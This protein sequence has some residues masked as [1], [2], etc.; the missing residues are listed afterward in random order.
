[1]DLDA[2][3]R[4]FRN[5]AEMNDRLMANW[6]AAFRQWLEHATEFTPRSSAPMRRAAG[7]H[8]DPANGIHWEQ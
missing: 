2:Q 8:A 1:L 3:E 5:H 6:D 4:R 7:H